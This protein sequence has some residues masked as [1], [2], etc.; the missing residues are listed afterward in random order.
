MKKVFLLAVLAIVSGIMYAGTRTVMRVLK[1]DVA[2]YSVDVSEIDSIVFV[3][4]H[5][6]PCS[7]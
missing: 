5:F 3:D 7:W 6:R 2:A 1:G 4:I